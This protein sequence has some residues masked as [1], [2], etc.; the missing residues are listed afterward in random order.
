MP[1]W[2]IKSSDIT[3]DLILSA[4]AVYVVREQLC[5]VLKVSRH[6]AITVLFFILKK[7]ILKFVYSHKLSP[8]MKP[9]ERVS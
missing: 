3:W 5:L 9:L 2:K 4:T 1:I 6:L 7:S 8:Q